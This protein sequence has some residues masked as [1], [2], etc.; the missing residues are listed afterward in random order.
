MAGSAV[1][2]KRMDGKVR[3]RVLLVKFCIIMPSFQTILAPGLRSAAG[4]AS[5]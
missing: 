2:T 3:L 1:S 4:A 5:H